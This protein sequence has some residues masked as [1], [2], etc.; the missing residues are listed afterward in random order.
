MADL[1]GLTLIQRLSRDPQ[2]ER[3][4]PAEALTDA[5]ESLLQSRRIPLPARW[6]E[7]SGKG[8]GLGVGDSVIN[9][10]IPPVENWRLANEAHQAA[11]AREVEQ[12]I[13]RFEP[14]IRV[15][16]VTVRMADSLSGR[17]TAVDRWSDQIALKIHA[18]WRESGARVEVE[19]GWGVEEHRVWFR[20]RE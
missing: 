20:R 1:R 3:A 16:G 19:A 14:R 11:L 15:L 9:Y 8:Y 12:A 7:G 5:L 4:T 13:E 2:L 17:D 18:E 6:R 10:G